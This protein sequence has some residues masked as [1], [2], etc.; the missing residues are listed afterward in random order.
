[1]RLLLVTWNYPPKVGGME[2][3]LSQLA[4]NLR[5]YADVHV[6]GPAG[7]ADV[8]AEQGLEVSRP[9]R[10]GL[11]RFAS[12]AFFRGI[13]LL[14][15]NNYDVIM[16][17]SALVTPIVYILGRFF[18]VPS[19]VYV[20]GLDLVYSSS[21]YQWM[22][23]QCL[24]RCDRV[25]A[26]SWASEQE[27]LHR[28]VSPDRVSIL[29]P[30]LDFSEFRIIPDIDSI[31]QRYE[32]GG[33]LTLLSAGRLARRKGLV[34]FV[35]HSLPAIVEKYPNVVFIIVGGN[36][37]LSL[38]HKEDIRSK[39]QA[40]VDRLRLGNYVRLLGWV[41]RQDLMDLYHACDVFVLPAIQVPG[42]IEGFGIVLIEAGAAGKPVI[43]TRLGGIK[44]AVVEGKSGI[45]VEAEKWDQL[46]GA[47][48]TLLADESLRREM[49]Q[50]G[51]ERAETELD[52][53]VV[54]R[55]YLTYLE[56]LLQEKH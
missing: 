32:L 14:R 17:G 38:T 53:P 16:A 24:P 37:S 41:D 25:F 26:N 54:A 29:H 42:D 34:E 20:H 55:R 46:S 52:W 5:P 19:V 43:S 23:K 1:M 21:I 13:N 8:D 6:I 56:A 12:Y 44:D 10:D 39:I 22:V 2:M 4:L 48:L 47:V 31:K 35:R 30:G 50:F 51:R 27:A 28:G 49:G 7:Q 45:L 18:Q 36:P 15:G 9:S 11:I 33:R 3:L 40:E